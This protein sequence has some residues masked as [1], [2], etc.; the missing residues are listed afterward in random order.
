MKKN[1]NG[2]TFSYSNVFFCDYSKIKVNFKHFFQ[3]FN[4][5]NVSLSKSNDY[6]TS[7][8]LITADKFI[9]DHLKLQKGKKK[10]EN[11]SKVLD[12]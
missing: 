7:T 6:K 11:I 3:K 8:V 5:R 4:V 2:K 9:Y 1:S 12:N 10:N